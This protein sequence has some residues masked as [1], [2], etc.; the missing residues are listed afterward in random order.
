MAL[1]RNVPHLLVLGDYIDSD[2]FWQGMLQRVHRYLAA[3][4]QAGVGVDVIDLPALGIRGNSHFPMMDR[5]SD[6]VAAL[7]Q[8]WMD[9]NGLLTQP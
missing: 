3:L 4:R 2:P 7:V 1:L 5:N 9:A 8:A 6:A